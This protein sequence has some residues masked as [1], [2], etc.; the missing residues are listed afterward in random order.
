MRLKTPC[1]IKNPN[2][3]TYTIPIGIKL[4]PLGKLLWDKTSN[5]IRAVYK[6]HVKERNKLPIQFQFAGGGCWFGSYHVIRAN[7]QQVEEFKKIS[8]P[9]TKPLI[10]DG[11]NSIN[12]F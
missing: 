3:E 11:S 5:G 12:R 8:N 7:D 10:A 1:I 9:F 6:I 2:G 4:Q